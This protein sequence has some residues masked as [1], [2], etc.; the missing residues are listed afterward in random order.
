[1]CFC[2][3]LVMADAGIKYCLWSYGTC[4][5]LVCGCVQRVCSAG[6]RLLSFLQDTFEMLLE[7][8]RALLSPSSA[9]E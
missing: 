5:L 3:L 6:N 7:M 9:H 2:M 1:M 4:L 8:L